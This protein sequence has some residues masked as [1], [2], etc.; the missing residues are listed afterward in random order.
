MGHCRGGDGP[1]SFDTI[2]TL[3]RWREQGTTPAQ[4]PASN[5]TSGLARPLCPFPQYAKYKGSG[6]LK[7]ADNWACAAP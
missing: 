7:N 6:D 1:W 4:I 5:P 3:E 2:R